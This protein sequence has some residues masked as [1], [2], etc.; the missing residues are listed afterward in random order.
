MHTNNVDEKESEIGKKDK[1]VSAVKFPLNQVQSIRRVR[2]VS[3]LNSNTVRTV[4]YIQLS[5]LEVD[6]A[7]KLKL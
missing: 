7:L 3:E 2:T 4:Q 5:P 6:L 1:K